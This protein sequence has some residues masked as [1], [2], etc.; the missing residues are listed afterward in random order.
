MTPVT[1][2]LFVSLLIAVAYMILAAAFVREDRRTHTGSFINLQGMMC[3]IVTAPIAFSLEYLGHKLNYR[4]NLQMGS[5]ILGCGVLVF[6][7]AFGLWSVVASAA[8]AR[9]IGH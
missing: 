4:S 9:P 8:T 2:K 7:F 3:S 1:S 5:A 6:W